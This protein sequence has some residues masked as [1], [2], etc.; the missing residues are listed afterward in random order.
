MIFIFYFWDSTVRPWLV[1]IVELVSIP[2]AGADAVQ[3][4]C[5]NGE[6]LAL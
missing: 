2:L 4:D 3:K 5:L 1:S 6:P